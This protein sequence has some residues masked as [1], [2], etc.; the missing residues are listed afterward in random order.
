MLHI[1]CYIFYVIGAKLDIN[2]GKAIR[3]KLRSVREAEDKYAAILVP[4]NIT[5]R[6]P[7]IEI[8]SGNVSYL[9]ESRLNFKSGVEHKL[10]ITLNS[11]PSKVRIDIGGEVQGWN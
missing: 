1:L 11:D 6:Q 7:L 3:L 9:L 8:L 10:N 4:Q 5:R 2:V